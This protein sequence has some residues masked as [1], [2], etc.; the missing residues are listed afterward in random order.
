MNN[1]RR[2]PPGKGFQALQQRRATL[3]PVVFRKD[4]LS[5]TEEEFAEAL[6]SE[7]VSEHKIEAELPVFRKLKMEAD[8]NKARLQAARLRHRNRELSDDVSGYED[9]EARAI[10][11]RKQN[12]DEPETL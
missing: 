2:E 1:W 6:R 9:A 10:K 3:N 11:R 4:F 12:D 8:E 5:M 7:R